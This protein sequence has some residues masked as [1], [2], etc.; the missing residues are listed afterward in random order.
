VVEVLVTDHPLRRVRRRSPFRISLIIAT[1]AA[2][3]AFGVTLELSIP[4]SDFTTFT[5]KSFS[6][7]ANS[8]RT[9]SSSERQAVAR[10]VERARFYDD[11]VVPLITQ[12]E[13]ENRD[14]AERCLTRID[15]VINGYHAGVEPFVQDMTS[16]STRFG[17]LRRMP[18]DWWRSD[19]RI[20]AFVQ[21]KFSQHLFSERQLLEDLSR[22][23]VDFQC[24]VTANQHSMLTRVQAALWTADL[25]TIELESHEVFFR[26]LSE[27]LSEYASRQGVTS[28]ENMIAAFVLGE[29]GAFAARSVITGLLARFAPTV[30]MSSA[31][32]A[33]ATVGASATGAGGGAMAGP[34]GAVVGF[35]AGLV[36]GLIVDWWMT[37]RF[38]AEL[39]GQLHTYIEDLR[40]AVVEGA[41]P[42]NTLASQLEHGSGR[43]ASG[44]TANKPMT[45]ASAGLRK[46]L[47][48]LCT[49]LTRAYRDR[50]FS[51]IVDEESK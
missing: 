19:D 24:E 34:V 27:Q 25:P 39:R 31:A 35:G 9:V 8:Q 40:F 38:E 29:V 26:G 17:I 51:Q 32:G 22:V 45:V 43:I 28:V 50:F 33:T 23:L 44:R 30:A 10:R 12:V 15:H 5:E 49:Q 3:L 2:L 48:E 36:V 7:T 14:A 42:G 1:I 6:G 21:E 41:R 4:G 37:E 20:E 47:P 13:V 11:A 18:G 46:A 16:I